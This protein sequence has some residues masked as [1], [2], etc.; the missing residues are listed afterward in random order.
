MPSPHKPK[1]LAYVFTLKVQ[2]HDQYAPLA[3][4][5]HSESIH[6]NTG[7]QQFV[8]RLVRTRLE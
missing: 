1:R 2:W 4:P 6:H 5:R 7:T 3:Q 8:G